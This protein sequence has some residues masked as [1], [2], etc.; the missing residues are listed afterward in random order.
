MASMKRELPLSGESQFKKAKVAESVANS[1]L[2]VILNPAD[3]DIDFNVEG[4]GLQ[5]S[6]L[7]EEGFAYCW[8]GARANTGITR[9]KYYFGCKIVS[10]QP[11]DMKD[12]PLDQQH[13]CRFG[14][15][16]VDDPVRNLG[17]TA[18]SFGYGGTGKF[19]NSGNFVNYGAKFGVGDTIICAVD[20]ESKP[21]ASIGFS[22]N[23]NWLGVANHFN[24]GPSGV[25]VSALFPHVLLKNVVVQLQFTIDDGLIPLEGY[26]P[27]AAAICDGN[28]MLGPTFS[29]ESDCE[30][31]MM[32]G[33]PAS[34]KT[35]WAE[36]W[37]KEH[38]EKRYILLGTNLALE[39]MKVPG[40][41]RK[42]NYGE[43]FD[44]LMDR[45]TK[46]F[47]VLQ[48]R[49]SRIPR[50]FIIDQTNV[51]KSARKRKLKPF[52]NYIKI[53][54]VV[55]PRPEELKLR[56]EKRFNEMG[57]EVPSEAVQE[58]LAK[59]TLPMSK[60]MPMADEYFDQV[61]FVELG[62]DESQ[63]SLDEMKRDTSLKPCDSSENS[64]SSRGGA[65][66]RQFGEAPVQPST[67]ISFENQCVGAPYLN[68]N[69]YRPLQGNSPFSYNSRHHVDFSQSFSTYD[70]T[71]INNIPSIVQPA[72][73][74]SAP[75][76][77]SDMRHH[78]YQSA[79]SSPYGSYGTQVLRPPTGIFL[80]GMHQAAPYPQSSSP[81]DGQRSGVY[82]PPPR[83][84]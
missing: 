21:M 39:Q 3:C 57:K 75:Y 54:A 4:K 42:N 43:R 9:G 45:A 83:G 84:Y 25:G 48:S 44:Q 62:R 31:I 13:D 12:T 78:P 52:A 46:I 77:L 29:N 81:V 28:S 82:P 20:L 8:S 2:R 64:L 34:G 49:A 68:A 53:A 38:P 72:H 80:N 6:A 71:R 67:A 40:L 69:S 50:N 61:I 37:V 7:Y 14:I 35:T 24:E 36:N 1:N 19:S 18:H 23:G 60:D 65:S 5:G 55:F 76:N 16:T 22:K 56:A 26:K 27:W 59:Y 17:E 70:S 66:M 11:V 73:G 33:L 32:V 63:R 58:M 51:Y 47:N 10:A 41:L 79:T 15:S 74:G 30:V